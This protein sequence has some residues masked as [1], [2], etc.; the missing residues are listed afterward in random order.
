MKVALL[1]FGNEDNAAR[2]KIGCD[3]LSLSLFPDNEN[4]NN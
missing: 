1:G 2:T 4:I 3:L